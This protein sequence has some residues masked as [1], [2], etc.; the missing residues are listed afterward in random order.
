MN[1][2]FE[3]DIQLALFRLEIRGQISDGFWE[4]CK[5]EHHWIVW[6]DAEATADRKFKPGRD[7][8]AVKSNYQLVNKRL[9]EA[10]GDRM[11]VYANIVDILGAEAAQVSALPDSEKWFLRVTGELVDQYPWAKKQAE[12]WQRIG[13]TLDVLKQALKFENI[14]EDDVKEELRAMSRIFKTRI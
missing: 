7:F 10:V 8:D 12:E 6:C 2:N 13:L 11:T 14:T 3:N 5:P 1:I 4:N 9:F